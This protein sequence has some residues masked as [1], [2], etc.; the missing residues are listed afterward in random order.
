MGSAPNALWYQFTRTFPVDPIVFFFFGGDENTLTTT[1]VWLN[2]FKK[3]FSL[4]LFAAVVVSA[5]CDIQRRWWR[6]LAPGVRPSRWQD[7]DSR[8]A[9]TRK[10]T[11][12]GG[13]KRVHNITRWSQLHKGIEKQQQTNLETWTAWKSAKNCTRGGG[14]YSDCRHQLK[15]WGDENWK[16][17]G[18][19]I[20]SSRLSSSTFQKYISEK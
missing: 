1:T 5:V 8:G 19:F 7:T 16:C 13:R 17:L 2:S 15:L 11:N 18:A 6:Q 20:F 3:E 9:H 10:R 14:S 4:S 12:G